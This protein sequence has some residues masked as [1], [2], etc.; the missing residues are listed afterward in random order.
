MGH[1]SSS[2]RDVTVGFEK[3]KIKI[4]RMADATWSCNDQV[5]QPLISCRLLLLALQRVSVCVCLDIC[6]EEFV[7]VWR[8]GTSLT[9]RWNKG[10]SEIKE[11]NKN[12][13]DTHTRAQLR[14]LKLIR[15]AKFTGRLFYRKKLP[16]PCSSLSRRF[17]AAKGPRL[18]ILFLFFLGGSSGLTFHLILSRF[19]SWNEFHL[20]FYWDRTNCSYF[21]ARNCN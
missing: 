1:H 17:A 3:N 9:G 19:S 2:S 12:K 6:S 11:K 13:R 18:S 10:P 7:C 21:A 5:G 20:S 8:V 15:P 4:W 14:N 16:C